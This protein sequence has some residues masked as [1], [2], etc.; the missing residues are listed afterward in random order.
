[1]PKATSS[2]SISDDQ[3]ERMMRNRKLAEERRLARLK[4]NSLET[5]GKQDSV[6]IEVD[7]ETESVAT[8]KHS[9]SHVI[10]SSDDEYGVTSVNQS[11]TVH[12]HSHTETREDDI[13]NSEAV[14]KNGETSDDIEMTDKNVDQEVVEIIDIDKDT[15]SNIRAIEQTRE[16]VETIEINDPNDRVIERNNQ[17]NNVGGVIE[18]DDESN[19]GVNEVIHIHDKEVEGIIE[20]NDP[21]T[22]IV[23][24]SRITNDT[25]VM[26]ENQNTSTVDSNTVQTPE[27]VI[28]D[29]I[30]AVNCVNQSKSPSKHN[31]DK[32]EEIQDGAKDSTSDKHV[33]NSEK[34]VQIAEEVL[35]DIMDV[36]FSDDF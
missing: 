19:Q 1:M 26:K 17:R 18:I 32:I 7:E 6:I 3:K 27:K 25:Q 5:S 24:Q 29:N 12:V 21:A 11:V 4:K 33:D 35:E 8:K 14:G 22:D 28:N 16:A 20:I 10:D 15:T 30:D 2:P 31:E 13:D 36:D 23:G 34:T 9:R